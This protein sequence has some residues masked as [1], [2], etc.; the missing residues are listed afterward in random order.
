[1]R[2]ILVRRAGE[3]YFALADDLRDPAGSV[4]LVGEGPRQHAI[5]VLQAG[6]WHQQDIGDA[7]AEADRDWA[8]HA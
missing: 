6:G 2:R 8:D 4:P 5:D 7:L 1:M 3:D